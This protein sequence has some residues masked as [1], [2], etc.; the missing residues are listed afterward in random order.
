M[1]K[2]STTDL[3]QQKLAWLHFNRELEVRSTADLLEHAPGRNLLEIGGG[4]GFVAKQLS[5][6]GYH[7]TSIDLAPRFPKL[8]PVQKGDATRLDFPDR[9]FDV[10]YSCH[11]LEEIH[12]IP[13]VFS[14]MNRV[15]K[16]NGV[17]VHIVATSWWAILTNLWHFLMLPAVILNFVLGRKRKTFSQAD[18]AIPE[19]NAVAREALAE[20]TAN[21]AVGKMKR[22][23][24]WLFLHPVGAYPTFVH[25]IVFFSRASWKKVLQANGFVVAE[26]KHGPI[27]QSGARVYPFKAVRMRRVL[28]RCFAGSLSLLTL[29]CPPKTTRN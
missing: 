21:T 25:E 8:Y 4:D 12:S 13:N 19:D 16:P 23:L 29:P 20:K 24:R 10:V 11:V 22:R 27:V 1:L 7:V 9:T 28:A 18:L 26:M 6:L 5:A 3:I 15:L 17:A 2:T 14:E